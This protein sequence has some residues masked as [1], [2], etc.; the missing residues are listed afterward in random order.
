MVLTRQRCLIHTERE[1]AARC[2][3]CERFFCRECV[4]EHGGQMTCA[5]CLR[6]IATATRRRT[7]KPRFWLGPLVATWRTLQ[8]TASVLAAW[9]F[10]HL[11][12]HWLINLP[13]EF[14][15]GNL[16]EN[17]SGQGDNGNGG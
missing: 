10:F 4:T 9:F 8:L 16:W 6:E 3:R 14:H 15:A 13:D 1:A 2:G 5:A 17:L 12:G 7:L 11:L